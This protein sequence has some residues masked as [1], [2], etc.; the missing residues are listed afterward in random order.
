MGGVVGGQSMVLVW[1]Y[2]GGGG[3]VVEWQGDELDH[4]Q[5]CVCVNISSAQYW[6]SWLDSALA[7]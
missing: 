4:S 1:F 3:K 6:K 7:R 5:L 2:E